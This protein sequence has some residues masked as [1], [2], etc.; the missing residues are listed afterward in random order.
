MREWEIALTLEEGEKIIKSW[1]DLTVYKGDERLKTERARSKSEYP[2]H[3]VVLTNRRFAIISKTIYLFKE[4]LFEFIEEI[5][6]KSIKDLEK[7]GRFGKHVKF[8]AAEDEYKLEAFTDDGADEFITKILQQ[9]RKL[10]EQ[11]PQPV[12]AKIREDV[13]KETKTDTLAGW[14]EELVLE[15]GE[16]I[17]K[18]C[19]CMTAYKDGEKLTP[20][21]ARSKKE[22]LSYTVFLT[23]KKLA[24][25]SQNVSDSKG[26]SF[27]L[28]EEIPLESVI[29]QA[30]GKRGYLFNHIKFGT[31]KVNYKLDGIMNDDADEFLDKLFRA[32]LA[33]KEPEPQP[34]KPKIKKDEK[35]K[36][37]ILEKVDAVLEHPQLHYMARTFLL[38]KLCQLSL[39]FSPDKTE[40]YWKQLELLKHNITK[41]TQ[42]EWDN[43]VSAMNPKPTSGDKKIPTKGF[44][45]EIIADIEESKK[46]FA[47]DV[48]EIIRRLRDCE[49]RLEK[50]RLAWERSQA[51]LALAK[52]WL[53]IDRHY[54]L[55]LTGKLPP[56]EQLKIIMEINKAKPL[57]TEE[58]NI[59]AIN[60]GTKRTAQIIIEFLDDEKAPLFLPKE[61]ILDV[62]T[63]IRE[64]IDKREGLNSTS[65]PDDFWKEWKKRFDWYASLAIRA[66]LMGSEQAEVI[67]TLVEE[68]FT[69]IAKTWNVDGRL[70]PIRFGLIAQVLELG[71]FLKSI[72]PEILEQLLGR[73]PSY[74]A[75]FVRARYAA[76][77]VS[78]NNVEDVY[79]S[80]LS[81]TG[82]NP[83]AEAWFLVHLVTH[84]LGAEAMNLAKKSVHA[85]TLLPRLRRAWLSTDPESARAVISPTDME[86]DIVGQ[87]LAQATV[88]DRITFLKNATL[89]CIHS[90]PTA[91]WY[92]P[93][94]KQLEHAPTLPLYSYYREHVN[95]EEKF[96]EYLRVFGYGEYKYQVVD[97]ALLE[98]LVAW[99]DEDSAQVR[100]LLENMWNSINVNYGQILSD[101]IMNARPR[102]MLNNLMSRCLVFA[103]DP[104]FLRHVSGELYSI[105]LSTQHQ[106]KFSVFSIPFDPMAFRNK[107]AA[108]ISELSPTLRDKILFLG[109]RQRVGDEPI[110]IHRFPDEKV[111][112][113]FDS[114][115]NLAAQLYNSDKEV[116][117][118]IPPFQLDPRY[119]SGWQVGVIQNAIP[120]ITKAMYEKASS[121]KLQKDKT[122][123]QET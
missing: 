59:V 33:L 122:T 8:R 16:R 67:P 86:Q 106:T 74:L 7:G 41:D 110:E 10:R 13:K 91:I 54:A 98:T 79:A 81:K 29:Y 14:N 52:A 6:L 61:I 47:S 3:I 89:E 9:K 72:T 66:N 56:N 117:E 82:Q 88:Q 123:P 2:S 107:A 121:K 108:V 60:S 17:I 80:L 5:P 34:E 101:S 92:S 12:K 76:L 38:L 97:A 48:D 112:L 118:I 64:S 23:S 113:T 119:T 120:A 70:W 100:Q 85:E 24:I 102:V 11:K 73:V 31:G 90:L 62:G 21:S 63:H 103:V 51:W 15:E 95:D 55:K 25:F 78:P 22:K 93:T 114:S 75:N 1:D 94:K 84:N 116:L 49:V 19:Y 40:H 32:K 50:K 87:F 35:K 53:E 20:E 36:M 69:F 39:L 65:S 71:V 58:W 44:S 45:A 57:T 104:E 111:G 99:S 27:K 43:L 30:K 28:I 105:H 68:I 109:V 26:E 96:S 18:S 83:E 37:D 42:K 4:D 46:F 115:L 77:T